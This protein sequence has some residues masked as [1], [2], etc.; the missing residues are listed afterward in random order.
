[1]EQI[2]FKELVKKIH[3]DLNPN[4]DNPGQKMAEI[5][6]HKNN[7]TQLMN[8]AIKWGFVKRNFNNN[9]WKLFINTIHHIDSFQLIKFKTSSG[10]KKAYF[11]SYI[12]R[13]I[14]LT[15]LKGIF[16]INCTFDKLDRKIYISNNMEDISFN[17]LCYWKNKVLEKIRRDTS[18]SHSRPTED[19]Q[20]KSNIIY[21][22]FFRNKIRDHYETFRSM[23]LYPNFNYEYKNIYVNY[24]G[25]HYKVIRTTP[26]QIV[27]I[28]NGKIQKIQL[29]TVKYCYFK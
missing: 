27:I 23:N 10:W 20:N 8:L 6:A 22:R 4:I 26:K 9:N 1:M 11:V 29:K 13:K 24:R 7:P 21:N 18:R 25:K 28:F 16:T 5:V 2:T 12:N 19:F 3:P 17:E 15:D 14:Y